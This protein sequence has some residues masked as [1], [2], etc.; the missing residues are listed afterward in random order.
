MSNRT[1]T[2][3]QL[4]FFTEIISKTHSVSLLPSFEA[5]EN[6]KCTRLG[7]VESPNE[8]LALVYFKMRSRVQ[9]CMQ[10]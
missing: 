3:F 9:R 1:K 7:L 6:N 4:Y 8:T 10:A 5:F 2:Y